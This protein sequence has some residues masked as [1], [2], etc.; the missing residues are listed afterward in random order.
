M[1]ETRMKW[2][3]LESNPE[4]FTSWCS[5]MGLD[6]SKYA[7]HDIYGT[8]PD[9]LA[10]VPQ[11]VAAVLLLF[12][13]TPSMEALRQQENEAASPAAAGSDIL[14]FKQTIGNA[15]GTIGLLHAL[16]NSTATSSIKPDSPLDT[17][18]KKARTTDDADERADILVNSKELQTAHE[19]TASQGQSQAPEDLDNV[20]LHFVCF[21]R[22]QDGELVELDG[23]GGR[24]GPLRRGKKVESQEDLLPVAVEFVKDNYMALNPEEVN[25]NLIAL[26]P[27]FD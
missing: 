16:A 17:L 10:M 11:P 9:L 2:V 24:K 21:V 18:F 27:S 13:I 3:P 26:G 1:T 20:L 14:W 22:S 7:F 8:D 25:F 12:P 19:T 23:S 4:L 15:C 5:S 6:T